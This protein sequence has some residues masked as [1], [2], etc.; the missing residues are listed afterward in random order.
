VV[1]GLLRKSRNPGISKSI[2]LRK[3]HEESNNVVMTRANSLPPGDAARFAAAIRRFDDENAK[4]PNQLPTGHGGSEARELVYARWLTDWVLRLAPHASEE[5]CL[6]ARCQHLCRWMSPRDS[7]PM[8]RAGYLKWRADLKKFH[9]Q[10]AGEILREAGYS[11]E[12]IAKVQA[13]NLKTNFPTDPESQILE[14]ALCL[15]FLEHQLADLAARTPEDK[16]INALQKTWKKMS[17]MARSEALKLSYAESE[18]KLLHRAAL[19]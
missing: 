18:Q 4:D 3:S 1:A 2:V 10:K 14:D 15:V 5:L 7:Y 19:I 11:A 13:L 12:M 6:A 9:A 16:M 17:P 8:T